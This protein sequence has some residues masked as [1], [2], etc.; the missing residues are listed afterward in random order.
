MTKGTAGVQIL[1]DSEGSAD[2][3]RECSEVEREADSQLG[4][5]A[6]RTAKGQGIF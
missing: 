3:N 5:A 2:E 1:K 6:A 4:I